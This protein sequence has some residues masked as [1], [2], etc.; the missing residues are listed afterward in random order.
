MI[1]IET[2]LAGAFIIEPE[3]FQDERGF[4]ICVWSQKEFA[5][6]GLNPK[7][8]E[9]NLSFNVRK[10]TLR[11]MHYQVEPYAQAKL[12]RCTTGGIY[13]VAVDLRPESKTFKQWVA[14]ELTAENRRSFYI[15]T[16]FAHGYQALEDGTEVFYQMSE[17]YA[18]AYARGVRWDDPAFGIEWPS[19]TRTIIARDRNYANFDS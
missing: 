17:V 11:G 7:L 19:D 4:L 15:P 12:V 10:G 2:K 6:H 8:V 14:V 18:P 13:D 1:L 5:A 3:K 9:C 16:G